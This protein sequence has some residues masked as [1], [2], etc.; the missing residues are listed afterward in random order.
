LEYSKIP[1]DQ[2]SKHVHE[3]R[4]KA[5][6]IRSYPCTGLGVWLAPYISHSPAY[7]AVVK[8]LQD[9][10]TLMDVGCFMGDDLRRLA[11]DGAPSDKMYG[12][13]IVS[14]W[15]VGF[16]MYRDEGSFKAHFIEAD[17]MKP[18]VNPR[19]AALKGEIDVISIS[20]VLHQWDWDSQIE[21]V[22]QLVKFSKPG[23]IVIGH[24][25]GNVNA[26]D[27]SFATQGV[28]QWRQNPESFRRL[29]DQAGEA[30]GTAWKT[31]ARLFDFVDIGWDPEAQKKLG[32]GSKIIDWVITRTK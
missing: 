6:A 7:A 8:R 9:G 13:D 11:Y 24:Q 19:L 31:E 16:A 26:G 28:K 29:W 1:V 3:I 12:V 32:E 21:C 30:S 5:F 23:T 14:H 20:A 15:D 18:E 22:K 2:Q 27:T 17:I 10:G 4:D 25:M